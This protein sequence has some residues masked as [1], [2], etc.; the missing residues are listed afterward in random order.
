MDKACSGDLIIIKKLH[1][2][3]EF[4]VGDIMEVDMRESDLGACDDYYLMTIDGHFV[5]D[6]QY[7]ILRKN[8]YYHTKLELEKYLQQS[9]CELFKMFKKDDGIEG[10][11]K[12]MSIVR[13]CVR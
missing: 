12:F 8:N 6:D 10:F 3:D 11:M 7:E 1:G 4:S 5:S 9:D 2:G 13:E